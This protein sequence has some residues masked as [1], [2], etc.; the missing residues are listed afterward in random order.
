M[1][2]LFALVI[3]LSFLVIIPGAW[4]GIAPTNDACGNATGP[5]AVNSLTSGQTI[6]ATSDVPPAFDCGTSI[7]APGVWYTVVG[8]GNTMTA[9]TCNNGI[10]SDG[11]ADYDTK[12]NIYCGDCAA[13][14][15]VAGV[16]VVFQ[17]D[18]LGLQR[19]VL[20]TSS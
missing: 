9:S 16:V 7:D 4:A 6:T 14:T 18:Y 15:C 13:L 3:V 5:L 20:P 8:T 19:Q 1:K 11:S 12:I 2:K 17:H 10:A